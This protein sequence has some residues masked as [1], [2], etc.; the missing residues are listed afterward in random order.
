MTGVWAAVAAVPWPIAGSSALAAGLLAVA[1]DR[2]RR[3][4]DRD[5]AGIR[6]HDGSGRVWAFT[7]EGPRFGLTAIRARTRR[8]QS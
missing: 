7:S 3:H 4:R 6:R 2:R 5:R 8:T 1:L